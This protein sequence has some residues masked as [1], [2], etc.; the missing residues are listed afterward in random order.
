MTE[1]VATLG[2]DASPEDH[3]SVLRLAFS[4]LMSADPELVKERLRALVNRV[5]LISSS[6]KLHHS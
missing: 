5:G 6:C 3:L 2:E 4:T 1:A